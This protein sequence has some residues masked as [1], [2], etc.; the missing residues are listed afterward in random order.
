MMDEILEKVHKAPSIFCV[1]L[2]EPIEA[3]RRISP[4]ARS[5]RREE[6]KAAAQD[7]TIASLGTASQ[8]DS[9]GAPL[10]MTPL[11]SGGMSAISTERPAS[12]LSAPAGRRRIARAGTIAR[13]CV[14][15]IIYIIKFNKFSSE[16]C[17]KALY[18]SQKKCYHKGWCE[19]TARF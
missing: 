6:R 16:T 2:S 5:R 15:N 4:K 10:R 17:G 1:I 9:A 13:P 14:C 11:V 18:K 8:F 19:C 12:L 3:S 7:P